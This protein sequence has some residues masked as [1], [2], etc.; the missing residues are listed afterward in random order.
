M[1]GFGLS[2]V[3]KESIQEAQRRGRI[4]MNGGY[5]AHYVWRSIMVDLKWR[6]H[7]AKQQAIAFGFIEPNGSPE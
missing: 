2:R 4:L 3:P 1:G 7:R 6:Y 5:E